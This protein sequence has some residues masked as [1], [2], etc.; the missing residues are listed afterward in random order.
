[1]YEEA[2]YDMTSSGFT[3]LDK[4]LSGCKWYIHACFSIGNSTD[5]SGSVGLNA[6]RFVRRSVEHA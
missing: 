3:T 6:K 2:Q 1:M 4:I 5:L